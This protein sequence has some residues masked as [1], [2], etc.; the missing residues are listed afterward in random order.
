MDESNGNKISDN[1]GISDR[2]NG[3][4]NDEAEN[5]DFARVV[6]ESSVDMDCAAKCDVSYERQRDDQVQE[7]RPPSTDDSKR[8]ADGEGSPTLPGEWDNTADVPTLHFSFIVNLLLPKHL[9]SKRHPKV[10][11]EI[12]KLNTRGRQQYGE[13]PPSKYIAV[14]S[15]A[16]CYEIPRMISKE[17]LKMPI[18]VQH[19]DIDVL[20]A[21]NSRR[22]KELDLQATDKQKVVLEIEE[23]HPG[24]CRLFINDPESVLR[25]VDPS[26][27]IYVEERGFFNAK[28]VRD[29]IKTLMDQIGFQQSTDISKFIVDQKGPAVGLE[30]ITARTLKLFQSSTS[31]QHPRQEMVAALPIT[32]PKIANDWTL[33]QRRNNW[34]SDTL[35]KSIVDEGCHVVPVPHR[36][37]KHPDIEWRLSFATSE[38]RLAKEVVTD[39]QRQCYVYLKLLRQVRMKGLDLL[40]SYHMKTAFL[41]SCERLPTEC[42]HENQGGCIIY[43]LDTLITFVKDRWL[44]SYFIPENNLLDHLTEDEFHHLDILLASIRTDPISPVLE[45][46]DT[47]IIANQSA[48]LPFRHFIGPVLDD[49]RRFKVHRNR[50]ESAKEFI[51]TLISF[52]AALLVDD[53]VEDSV[54]YLAD[55][56]DFLETCATADCFSK[57]LYSFISQWKI[58]T[59]CIR[60]LEFAVDFYANK[61]PDIRNVNRY[62]GNFYHAYSCQHPKGSQIN[63]Q[64]LLKA[65]DHF[66]QYVEEK[67]LYDSVSVEFALCN[68]ATGRIDMCISHLKD[69]V[70]SSCDTQDHSTNVNDTKILTL[71][72][73][74][75]KDLINLVGEPIRMITLPSFPLALYMLLV[76]YQQEN[77]IKEAKVA[78]HKANT[79][80]ECQYSNWKEIA[81]HIENLLSKGK[82]SEITAYMKEIPTDKFG[83]SRIAV[84]HTVAFQLSSASKAVQ[85]TDHVMD[86]LD[87]LNLP[88]F[89]GNLACLHFASAFEYPEESDERITALVRAE[90]L[91]STFLSEIP[92]KES[93]T[94]VDYAAFLCNQERWSEAMDILE[95]FLS[96]ATTNNCSNSYGTIEYLT[97][98]DFLKKEVDIHTKI[99][100]PSRAFA[101]YYTIKCLVKIRE[102]DQKI[103]GVKA[104]FIKFCTEIK[105]SRSFSLLGYSEMLSENWYR[106][107][108][109]FCKAVE[110]AWDY[111]AA[112]QNV[113]LCKSKRSSVV[114][115]K[116]EEKYIPLC[117]AA[118]LKGI[119]PL[120]K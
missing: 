59:Q 110:I 36:H 24:Y 9:I 93:A 100:A 120:Q 27:A 79:I 107:E 44:P 5:T 72:K 61:Y 70:K 45:F 12:D 91:F 119:L 112:K 74:L 64:L 23:V 39:D 104:A 1:I 31:L 69:Y 106:A 8:D 55:L 83:G 108:H 58:V 43:V 84:V 56:Y 41:Y 95:T 53:K 101:Y 4:Q 60:C 82:H 33:R 65:T 26:T 7:N 80:T 30:D 18:G 49:F 20:V 50:E 114:E 2:N 81:C 67:G 78:F 71:E 3:E 52:V 6:P 34:L 117:V 11:Q 42:W 109:W 96:K 68:M 88:T 92:N 115:E 21:W 40:S 28:K 15:S 116:Y 118:E 10:E 105:N 63:R 46:T 25:G 73:N 62:L 90:T 113:N 97:L 14:G 48:V 89:N 57:Y 32:W 85:F 76:A 103:K 22:I 66:N 19:S 102:P 77:N 99:E 87:D 111:T 16:E 13:D 35:I 51:H 17:P 98:D 75:R 47:N 54:H 38:V 94:T 29:D 86:N 37:T